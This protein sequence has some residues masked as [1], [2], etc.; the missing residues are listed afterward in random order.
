MA[1][2]KNFSVRGEGDGVVATG[3][4]AYLAHSFVPKSVEEARQQHIFPQGSVPSV[5][6]LT[7]GKYLSLSREDNCIQER[8]KSAA[9][10][11]QCTERGI[12]VYLRPE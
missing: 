3:P 12:R 10:K 5:L 4:D 6:I 7:K 2:R 8:S 11:S 9:R 1:P